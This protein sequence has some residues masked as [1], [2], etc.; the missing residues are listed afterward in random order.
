MQK[1]LTPYGL[2]ANFVLPSRV[3]SAASTTTGP[4]NGGASSLGVHAPISDFYSVARPSPVSYAVTQPQAPQAHLHA[5][6][7][8]HPT[9][10]LFK[11][12]LTPGERSIVKA[13]Q[14]NS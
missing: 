14:A 5:K 12:K 8:P 9:E 11:G 10:K 3:P 2:S 4:F 13:R 6:A 7:P 1:N